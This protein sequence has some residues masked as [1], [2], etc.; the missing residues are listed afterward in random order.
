MLCSYVIHERKSL[1]SLCITLLL[2]WLLLSFEEE[3]EREGYYVSF[4]LIKKNYL[5]RIAPLINKTVF[6]K[7]ILHFFNHCVI[8]SFVT[9]VTMVLLQILKSVKK[10][11]V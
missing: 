4:S 6:K 5:N 1:R 3:E 11:V 8:I 2:L 10:S 7:L 9:F